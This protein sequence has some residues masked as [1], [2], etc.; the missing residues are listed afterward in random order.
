MVMKWLELMEEIWNAVILADSMTWT[1][2]HCQWHEVMSMECLQLAIYTLL[3]FMSFYHL[4]VMVP[5]YCWRKKL[6]ELIP[7]LLKTWFQ[8]GRN[9]FILKLHLNSKDVHGKL[10]KH[11]LNSPWHRHNGSSRKCFETAWHECLLW[12]VNQ[13]MW[14]RVWKR[15]EHSPRLL[16]FESCNS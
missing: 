1:N 10:G 14:V 2:L 12:Q 8:I 7:V 4:E 11:D 16:Q 9:I 5:W 13:F 15:D 3:H 6:H